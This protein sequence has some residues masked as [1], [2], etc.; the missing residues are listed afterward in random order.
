[1]DDYLFQRTLT[2]AKGY[3]EL[4]M[5]LAAWETIEALPFDSCRIHPDVIALRVIVCAKLQR[6]DLGAMFVPLI[7]PGHPVNA[8]SAAGAYYLA[9]AAH[10]CF[11]GQV[12]LARDSVHRLW[13][14]YP[15]GLDLI[16]GSRTL[17]AMWPEILRHA[18]CSSG[19]HEHIALT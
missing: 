1:M 2:E 11:S 14:V 8:R 3:L 6:W 4:D 19:T 9:H 18:P 7:E 12:D 17:L 10:M 16:R 15:E 13:A 5:P